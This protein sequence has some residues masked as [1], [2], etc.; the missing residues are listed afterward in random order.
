MATFSNITNGNSLFI[1]NGGSTGSGYLL[2]S[3]S[4]VSGT[5][6]FL[7]VSPGSIQMLDSLTGGRTLFPFG[8]GATGNFSIG[9]ISNRGTFLHSGWAA[10]YQIEME[11]G[12]LAL[13]DS[14]AR[15]PSAGARSVIML[16]NGTA[17]ANVQ[18]TFQLRAAD[19]V[20]GNSAPHFQTE[21]GNVIKIYRE[22]TSVAAATRVH[23]NSQA[24]HTDDTFDGYTIAQVV[25]A[26]R[27]FGQL[28]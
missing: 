20:A 25:K 17:S 8:S 16:T 13:Q 11:N 7:V 28:A 5:N 3:N 1:L 18:D 19:I 9:N 23:N 4:T 15:R 21:N 2:G 27:N 12:N 24:I 22:T 26:L 10:G 14:S 6:K